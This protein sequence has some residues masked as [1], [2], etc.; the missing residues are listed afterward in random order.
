MKKRILFGILILAAVTGSSCKKWLDVKPRDKVIETTLLENETGFLSALNGVYLNMTDSA[1]YGGQVTM[2]MVEILGQRYNVGGGHKYYKIASYQYPDPEIQTLFGNTWGNMY[3]MVA[4]V[5]K[6]LSVIDQKKEVF[7]GKHYAWVKGEAL[8]LRAMIH[9]DLFR[10]FGP[11]YKLD[12]TALSLPYYSSFTTNYEDYLR[13]NVFIGKVLAD[14][15]AA[16]A[17]LTDDLIKDGYTLGNA[18]SDEGIAWSFRNLR[19]NYFAVKG[20]KA[21][22][23]LYRGDKI[24]ALKNATDVIT[25][26]G[27]ILPFVKLGAVQ[28][29]RNADRVFAPE[30]LFALQDSRRINKY[31]SYF[32]PSLSDA[33]ILTAVQG[34]LTS[35]FESNTNDYRYGNTWL[36]PGSNL[37]NYRCFFKYADVENTNLRFRNLIP[38]IRMSEMYFI[39]AESAPD[40]ASGLEYLNAVRRGRGIGDAPATAGITA[41]LLKDYKREFYGEGQMFF[42]YKRNATASIPGG[43][44]SGTITMGKEKYVLPIPLDE[45]RFRN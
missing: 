32:D 31:K 5:N 2:Q 43:T 19:L 44:G 4:N 20:L 1:T 17:L 35:E 9:F 13:G 34:R 45:S 29:A 23:C 18:T 6:I 14:L 42:Y 28:D 39:A 16:E 40:P 12:S 22:V 37:K 21:R 24:S 8:A 27:A 11:V 7:T 25:R 33:E 41:E 36:V 10:L 26:A 38:L 30:L 3:K 15:D